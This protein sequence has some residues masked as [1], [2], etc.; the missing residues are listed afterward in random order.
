MTSSLSRRQFLAS[1]VA[2]AAATRLHSAD[3]DPFGGFIFGIQSYT[4]RQ[5]NLE[6]A[7]KRMKECG[8]QY[9]EF[10]RNH[11]PT[12]SSP[13]KLKGI[14]ALCTEY[15]VKPVAFGVEKFTKDHDKN[16]KLFD[17]AQ[18]IG[19]KYMSADPD[20]DSF[21]SLDKLCEK[22]GIAIAIHPHGPSGKGLHRWYSPTKIL[23]AVKNHN[24]LIGTCLDT[25][26]LI[27]TQ[28]VGEK[29]DPVE[30]IKIMGA[31]NFGLHLKDHDN[32]R[33]TDVVFG[34]PYGVL[35]VPGVLKALREVKFKGYIAI[36]YEANP[37][38]PS[39]DV[40]KCVAYVQDAVK[41]LG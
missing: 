20:P 19:I 41:K 1:S 40:Q 33:K 28:Q 39:A 16:Q 8:V 21:D 29:L 25:G 18:A 34:S 31:R 35:D 22:T 36:E 3:A 11:I 27:R 30:Q 6:Q 17:F 37:S 23:E 15:N 24:P 14:L 26:H 4:F 5:F 32:K 10:F 2:L 7:L 13:D 12:D 38:D 9:A